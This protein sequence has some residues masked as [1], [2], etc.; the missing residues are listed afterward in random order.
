MGNLDITVALFFCVIVFITGISFAKTAK[1]TSSFFAAGGAVPWWISGVSLFMSFFSVGTFVVWGAI[2]Y[3]DGLVAVSIQATMCVAGLLI[4]LY[5]A[6]KW[7][8]TGA[9]TVAEFISERLGQKLGKIYTVLFLLI[10]M[11]TA[12]AFLYPVG[13]IIQVSTGIP[14]DTSILVLGFL[15]LVYTAVGG[16]WAVLVTDVL[17]FVVLSAAVIIVVPLAFDQIGGVTAFV[18]KAPEGFFALYNDEYSWAFLAAFLIYNTIYI[19]GNWA[20]VQRY[21]SVASPKDARKVAWLF[22]ALYSISPFIWMLPPMIYRIMQPELSGLDNEGAYLLVSK[23]VVPAGLLGMI[24]GSMVFATASSVNTTLNISAGVFTNDIYGFF[25]RHAS[26]KETMHVARISTFLFGIL[27]IAVALLVQRLGGIVEVVLSVAAL[28]GG[29]MFMPPIWALFSKRQTGFSILATSIVT[30]SINLF[31]KMFA[32]AS[33]G[34]VLSRTEEMVLGIVGP[35]L[36]LLAFEIYYV[37]TGKESAQFEA[38][39]SNRLLK[40]RKKQQMNN[41]ASVSATNDRGRTVISYGVLAIGVMIALL[42]LISEK[43]VWQVL[44]I[45]LAI[46]LSAIFVIYISHKRAQ[47]VS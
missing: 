37:V 20:Y 46:S 17:Q 27:T 40:E 47:S 19:G 23:A 3:S 13:K 11:F 35:I 44:A 39:E 33:I 25:R 43:S 38:Y 34:V 29:A 5:L 16:L 2:A 30:F 9:L 8:Q 31:F 10:S 12:G 26:D 4:G 42:G 22:G 6:P 28:T 18:D 1:N 41:D 45:G 15:I 21:T 36:M 32:E 14:I 7:N 24:L